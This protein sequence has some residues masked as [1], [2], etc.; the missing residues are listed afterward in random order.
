MNII[1]KAVIPVAGLGTRFMPITKAIPKEMLPIIDIPIAHHI[2]TEASNANINHIIFITNPNKPS[3]QKYFEQNPDFNMM[4]FTYVH[5]AEQLGLGHAVSCAEPFVGNE[6]FMVMLGDLV[7]SPQSR[8]LGSMIEGYEQCKKSVVAVHRVK[9]DE[10]KKYGVVNGPE[11]S[12]MML[13]DIH[14]MAEKPDPIDAPGPWAIPGRYI[15]E[16]RIFHHLKQIK[17]GVGGEYQ[18]TD[19]LAL[20]AK[21]N[22]LMAY[23]LQ[24]QTFDTGDKVQYLMAN[25]EFALER[26]DL[27]KDL[28]HY[29]HHKLQ[30]F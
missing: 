4:T 15:L 12:D 26:E 25:I 18:L 27:K 21:E 13:W 2:V 20:L 1:Q 11:S 24:E 6:P 30:S 5:Q 28:S 7:F 22:A 19:A 23:R 8:V 14:S 9:D 29:L 3:I 10:I 17:S 16:P